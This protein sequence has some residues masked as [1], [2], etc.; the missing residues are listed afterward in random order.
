MIESSG[1]KNLN[2]RPM[3]SGIHKG[4]RAGGYYGLMPETVRYVIGITPEL[5][6]RFGGF[7][8][9][10]AKEITRELNTNR[11]FDHEI[12]IALWKRL[13]GWYGPEIAAYAWLNGWGS[14]EN[15]TIGKIRSHT[16]VRKY[17]KFYSA[18][19]PSFQFASV[20]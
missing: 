14:V 20:P 18:L 3:A 17:R 16:Y 4:S 15:I 8:K 2:H 9:R 19:L 7:I 6:R 5:K 10:P 11:V 12:A 1:G 13:R